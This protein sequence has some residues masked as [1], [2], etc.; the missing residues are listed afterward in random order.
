MN[1]RLDAET[2]QMLVEDF[3]STV[4]FVGA[5]V[6]ESIEEIIDEDSDLLVRAPIVTIMG[7]VD[8]GKTSLMDYIRKTNVIAGESGGITQ[9][10][11]A[12]EVTLEDG[13]KNIIFRYSWARSLYSNESKRSKGYR[14]CN[15]CCSC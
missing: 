8:H 3:G 14:Y 1:Q 11:G 9:H 12:Y 15:C 13:K 4:E 5:D 7:H 2:I 6:Q 10:I